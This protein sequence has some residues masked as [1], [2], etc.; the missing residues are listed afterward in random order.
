MENKE[1]NFLVVDKP[2]IFFRKLN[3]FF[4]FQINAGYL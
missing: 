2:T 4:P 3:Y 1:F